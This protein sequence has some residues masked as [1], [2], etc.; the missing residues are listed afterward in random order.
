MIIETRKSDSAAGVALILA[1]TALVLASLAEFAPGEIRGNGDDPAESVAFLRAAGRFYGYSGLALIL[2][3]GALIVGVLGVARMVRPG[4]LSLAYA[5]STAFGVLA[6]GFLAVAG[7]LRLNATGTVLHIDDLDPAWGE[8]AYL[9]VQMAGTQGLLATGMIG[10]CA[11]LVATVVVAARRRLPGLVAAGLPAAAVL[12]ILA[13]DAVVPLDI[14]ESV[15]FAYVV[16]FT[17]GLPLGL[18][19]IGVTVLIPPGARRFAGV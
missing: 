2:G 16:A 12:A 6:G 11:W 7:V 14:A 17:I 13:V 10:L 3:G 15:F 5:G 8:S 1:A 9:A 18:L 4:G 19:A